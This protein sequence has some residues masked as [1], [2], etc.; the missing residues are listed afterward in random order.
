MSHSL[1]F[2]HHEALPIWF[3]T[4]LGGTRFDLSEEGMRHS[5]PQRGQPSKACGLPGGR[6]EAERP[7]SMAQGRG[8][9]RQGLQAGLQR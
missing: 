1:L 5:P 7:A 4:T 3:Q 8:L 6:G 2:L 9:T